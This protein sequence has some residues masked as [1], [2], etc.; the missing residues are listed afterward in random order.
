[1]PETQANQFPINEHCEFRFVPEAMFCCSD[2]T[3]L[4]RKSTSQRLVFCRRGHRGE[5]EHF[6]RIVWFVEFVPYD[7]TPAGRI[8][9]GNG[10]NILSTIKSNLKTHQKLQN[11]TGESTGTGTPPTQKPRSWGGLICW[12]S[13]KTRSGVVSF[14]VTRSTGTGDRD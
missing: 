11:S 1:M 7:K 6:L 3:Q 8:L 5:L 10:T 13:P 12:T 4:Q 14:V 2:K 9:S